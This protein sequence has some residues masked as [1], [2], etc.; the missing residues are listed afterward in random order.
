MLATCG[1]S[2]FSGQCACRVCKKPGVPA[3]ALYKLGMV[4]PVCDP[5]TREIGAGD[6]KFKVILSYKATLKLSWDIGEL[7]LET[8]KERKRRIVRGEED[9]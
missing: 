3:P 7:L 4:Q 9:H 2:Y 1:S 6:Q 8:T 5:S